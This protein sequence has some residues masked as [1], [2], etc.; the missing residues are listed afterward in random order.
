MI[1]GIIS[2]FLW[3]LNLLF[4]SHILQ[5]KIK[6]KKAI[7]DRA[8]AAQHSKAARAI[9]AAS[10]SCTGDLSDLTLQ[11]AIQAG[12][13]VQLP[14]E[15]IDKAIERGV[16]PS[17]KEGG[18]L[19]L[20]RYDGMIPAGSSGKVAVIIEALTENRNR[21]AANV[22]HMFSKFGGEMLPT[23][24]NDWLFE[25]VGLIW[26]DSSM[27]CSNGEDEGSEQQMMSVELNTDQLLE[28]ALEAGATDMEFLEDNNAEETKQILV[29]C[30]PEILLSIV[31]TLQGEGYT[32]NQFENQWL[33]KDEGNKVTV[34][35]EGVT[36]F[37]KFLEM[38]E[39][40]LDVT[41]VF[42]NADPISD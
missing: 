2:G 35:E 29:K 42:H 5:S 27:K 26:I 17:N 13:T 18:E 28:C 16:N 8:R 33:L 20:R 15:R 38:T 30:E 19:V 37:D 14:K 40:D 10:R 7:N 12:R 25:H 6:R 34:D 36:R 32:T 21:T 4:L 3:V 23:G 9:E 31:K 24:S 39:E 22:R 11:S 1:N 41:N